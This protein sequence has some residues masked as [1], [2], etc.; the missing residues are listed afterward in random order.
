MPCDSR[1]VGTTLGPFEYEV[2]RFWTMAYAAGLGDANPRYLDSLN[3]GP[4]VAH[5]VFPVGLALRA[6][7]PMDRVF[8][9]AG[10]TEEESIRRVHATQDMVF[11]RSIRPP[12]KLVVST[13][14][15]AMERRRPGTYV[16]TRYDIAETNGAAVATIHWGRIFRGVQMMGPDRSVGEIPR[17][18]APATR[19]GAPRAEMAIPIAATAAIVYTACAR[20]GHS[21]NFHTDTTEARRSGLSAPILMGVATLAMCVSRIVD[22]EAQGDPERV[23]R[24]YGRFGAMVFM[25]SQVTLRLLARERQDGGEAVFFEAL[26]A[27][28]GRAIRDGLVMLHG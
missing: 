24:V 20:P 7:T 15:A 18:P 6:M 23:T 16:V 28:G 25:P 5:P 11:Y 19:P 26:S 14:L 22:S 27:Q 2:D 8:F 4:L 1:L 12:A 17:V 10:L 13:T 21:I 9:E 3:C